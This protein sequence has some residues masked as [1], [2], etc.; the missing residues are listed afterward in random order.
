MPISWRKFLSFESAKEI[1]FSLACGGKFSESDENVLNV[2][3]ERRSRWERGEIWF[4]E[5]K[6]K[7]P[8]VKVNFE[9]KCLRCAQKERD[10]LLQK[11]NNLISHDNSKVAK[12]EQERD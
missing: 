1:V 8:F 9:V 11:H 6:A 5:L 7:S 4:F 10:S 12:K 2:S 3:K